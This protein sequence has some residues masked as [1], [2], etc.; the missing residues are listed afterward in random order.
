MSTNFLSLP[1]ELRDQIYELVLLHQE[2]ISPWFDRSNQLTPA[3]FRANKTI[4]YEATSLFY[5]QNRFDFASRAIKHIAGF[6][7]Q[8]G[9]NNSGY[10]RNI[11]IGFPDFAVNYESGNVTLEDDTVDILSKIQSGCTNLRTLMMSLRFLFGGDPIWLPLNT[12]ENF[13]IIVKIIKL[14]NT[15]L[16][17]IS[18]LQ[19]II[20][21]IHKD[22][23][24][25]DLR[26]EMESYGWKICIVEIKEDDSFCAWDIW[27]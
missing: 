12:I 11:C 5:S 7:E 26:R 3:L 15:R 14:V 2:P 16:T 27:D 19:E 22:G 9:G 6:L 18:S 21:E 10:I 24:N 1:R 25:D 4:H 23:A 17:A 8:I 20:V 13:E